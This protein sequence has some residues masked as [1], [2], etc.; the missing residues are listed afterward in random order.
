M[1]IGKK[2]ILKK[3]FLNY[4]IPLTLTISRA[5]M[6]CFIL[7]LYTRAYKRCDENWKKENIKKIFPLMKVH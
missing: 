4:K 5:K 1:K 3:Y 6:L 7:I 2:K